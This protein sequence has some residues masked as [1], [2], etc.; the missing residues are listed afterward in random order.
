MASSP[1]YHVSLWRDHYPSFVLHLL[2]KVVYVA[3]SLAPNRYSWSFN[4]MLC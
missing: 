1:P 3:A 2:S 4:Y